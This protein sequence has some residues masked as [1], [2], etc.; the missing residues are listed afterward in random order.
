MLQAFIVLFGHL[1]G[2]AAPGPIKS[3]WREAPDGRSAGAAVLGCGNL[4][5][6]SERNFG[7]LSRLA[8]PIETWIPRTTQARCVFSSIEEM[9]EIIA[10]P[11]RFIC[12]F[13]RLTAVRHA[14]A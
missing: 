10:G 2:L 4:P 12:H 6:P 13:L 11:P 7:S 9:I 3:R 14:I 8:L 5:K 1:C